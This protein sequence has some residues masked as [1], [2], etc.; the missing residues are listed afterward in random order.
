M[1][2]ASLIPPDNIFPR[3]RAG[4]R[5][6]ALQKMLAALEEQGS[7]RRLTDEA[8]GA[9]ELLQQLLEREL[10]GNTALGGGVGYPHIRSEHFRD[11]LL[12]LAT[13]PEGVRYGEAEEPVRLLLLAVVP[14]QKN[15][16]LLGVVT[17]LSRIIADAELLERLVRAEAADQVLR[18]LEEA[19]LDV[20]DILT[21]GDIMKRRFASIGPEATI[22]AAA[23]L[24]HEAHRDVLAVV[25]DEGRLVGQVSARNLFRSCLPAYFAELPS[26]RFLRDF[27]P[28]EQFLK[29]K[30]S[31]RVRDVMA[32][33]PD[34]VTGQTTLPEV[35][36][37]LVRSPASR[38]YV[39]EDER[40]VGVIDNFSI[41]DK[42]LTV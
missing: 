5:R 32:E 42:I 12:A 26:M 7:L 41:I 38:L 31:V 20:K 17:C 29:A 23:I 15:A 21:A 9:E 1:K 14:P 10:K 25:N 22:A 3:L 34:V 13:V 28:F 35:I 24:M 33:D 6:E 37:L 16:L 2:L 36:A 4:T 8:T 18:L 11:F 19:D 39:V 40:L 30:A 27:D